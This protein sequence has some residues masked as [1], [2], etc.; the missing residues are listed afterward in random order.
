MHERS[1]MLPVVHCMTIINSSQSNCV[2][3]T[4]VTWQEYG[5]HLKRNAKSLADAN[6]HASIHRLNIAQRADMFIGYFFG[7]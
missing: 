1:D 6:V 4:Q 2:P 7:D 3:H 5:V